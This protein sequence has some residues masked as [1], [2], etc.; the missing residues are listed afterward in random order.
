MSA[1]NARPVC[2]AGPRVPRLF[3]PGIAD[4]RARLI[5]QMDAQWVNGT[6]LHYW[7]FDGPEPQKQAVRD[8]FVHWKSLGIGLEFTETATRS[9]A[10]VRIAFDQGDGS[11]SYIGRDIL[12]IAN[13]DVTMNFGWDLTDD[14]G[15]TTALHEIGHSLGMPHEH[16]NPFAG[17]VW[18][19]PKVYSYFGGAPNNWP[20]SQTFQNVLKKL[21]AQEVEGSDWDPDSVME[22]W[23]P[24]GLI[25]RPE[26][27][28]EGLNPPGGLSALDVEWVMRFYPALPNAP[29]SLSAFASAP[30]VL[31]PGGQ[32]NFT[33]VPEETRSYRFATFGTADTVLVLFEEVDGQLRHLE[34]DDDGGEDR[35]A[36]F[37]VKLFKGRRYVA[38]VR[39]YWAGQSGQTALMYW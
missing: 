37:K 6:V 20:R 3:P 28:R 33:I 26:Q 17:I 13:T 12:G 27:Y 9:E 34:S 19:E 24:A 35:N 16:Q 5:R 29:R 22:Y 30:L 11:W 38:R 21:N 31:Q 25:L 1:I 4:R 36:T 32:A 23:F 39:L 2:K 18:D 8:A 15:R 10:E 14:Y 7:F